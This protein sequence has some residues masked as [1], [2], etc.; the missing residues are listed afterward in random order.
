MGFY[1]INGLV[2]IHNSEI[3]PS[4]T[5]IDNLDRTLAEDVLSFQTNTRLHIRTGRRSDERLKSMQ[6]HA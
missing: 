1:S 4:L 5:E 3:T 2:V 6:D